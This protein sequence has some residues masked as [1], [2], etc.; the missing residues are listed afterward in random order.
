VGA[1]TV[2]TSGALASLAVLHVLWGR[3]SSFPYRTRD[4]LA[5][6]VVG[7]RGVPPPAA[8]FAV[9]G[10]L[11]TGAA[12]VADVAPVPREAR[13]TALLGM[14][15]LLGTRSVLGFAGRTAVVSPDSTSE[16]FVRLDRRYFAP[17][18]LALAVGSLVARGRSGSKG[19]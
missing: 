14:A 17:L 11:A 3:G 18:C 5:D 2:S 7:G 13:R 8:C 16:T 15:G 12:L 4:E 19:S 1:A 9:A 10:A 6:A